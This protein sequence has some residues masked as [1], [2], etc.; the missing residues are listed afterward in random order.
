MEVDFNLECDDLI[1][2][3]NLKPYEIQKKE[4][5]KNAMLRFIA[6]GSNNEE[7]IYLL[8]IIKNISWF[9]DFQIF[10]Y[11]ASYISENFDENTIIVDYSTGKKKNPYSNSAGKLCT[12]IASSG[13]VLDNSFIKLDDL[14]YISPKINKFILMDDFIGSGNYLLR[15]IKNIES[16]G[17]EGKQ[18][19][20]LSYACH[21]MGKYVIE[22]HSSKNTITLVFGKLETSYLQKGLDEK[23]LDFISKICNKCKY[24][25]LK[26][27]YK[28]CGSMVSLN[29]LSPN[30]NLSMLYG[31]NVDEWDS[32]L[33]RDLNI[34][35]FHQRKKNILLQHSF[36]MHNFYQNNFASLLS[37]D[38][39]KLLVLIYNCYGIGEDLLKEFHLCS[40]TEDLQQLI[41]SLI[42]KNILE[43]S[44]FLYIIDKNVLSKLRNFNNSL[45]EKFKKKKNK[46]FY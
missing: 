33:D 23:I 24:E 18:I 6:N 7:K 22:N 14:K 15:I 20:V 31:K 28:N 27:G 40:T 44:Y 19:I 11:I 16:Q 41:G 37:Y 3:M 46:K 5:L 8:N 13:I 30:N 9:W 43:D 35:I 26:F 38:E 1:K 32:L 36:L 29:F 45:D 4:I 12:Y 25:D 10:D 17:I 39:F 2:T 34:I 42:E 21:T